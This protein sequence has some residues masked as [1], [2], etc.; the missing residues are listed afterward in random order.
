MGV[1]GFLVL[2]AVGGGLALHQ[3]FL[4]WDPSVY[5][6]RTSRTRPTGSPPAHHGRC[7]AFNVIGAAIYAARAADTDPV[8]R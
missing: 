8:P 2:A 7:G 4:L 3:G 6:S 5:A 1:I